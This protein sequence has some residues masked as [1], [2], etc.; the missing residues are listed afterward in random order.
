MTNMSVYDN[1]SIPW[2]E[3]CWRMGE[4]RGIVLETSGKK[5]LKWK[6]LVLECQFG[7]FGRASKEIT[8]ATGSEEYNLQVR[9]PLMNNRG[10]LNDSGTKITIYGVLNKLEEWVWMDEETMKKF[11]EDTIIPYGV[12]R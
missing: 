5:Q 1:D 11:G 6:N 8:V 10:V 9:S 3:G 7:K 4:I 2:K 12:P